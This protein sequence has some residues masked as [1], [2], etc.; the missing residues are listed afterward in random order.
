MIGRRRQPPPYM[1]EGNQALDTAWR[2]HNAIGE[3][4]ARVDAKASFALALETAILASITTL[5]GKDRSL[6]RLHGWKELLPY[7]L[8][9]SLL[10]FSALWILRV[11]APQLRGSNTKRESKIDF[12]YFGHLRHWKPAELEKALRERE[13]L[14]VLSRQLVRMSDI[15]WAKHRR[16]QVSL[17]GSVIGTALVTL[18]GAAHHWQW[19]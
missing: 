11:V 12:V 2:I 18:A 14:P 4:T 10:V 9:V 16:L 5:S 6:D 8:G 17:W 19:L 3:W 7:W 13:L 15:A 1:P